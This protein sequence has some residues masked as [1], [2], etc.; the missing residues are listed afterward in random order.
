MPVF[1]DR[2]QGMVEVLDRLPRVVSSLIAL[3]VYPEALSVV[4]APVI[5]YL[6]GCLFLCIVNKDRGG[7]VH[8]SGCKTMGIIRI[9]CFDRGDMKIWLL[10]SHAAG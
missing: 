5:E 4:L 1:L 8:P 10:S 6:L 7:F 2:F 3:P 9:V